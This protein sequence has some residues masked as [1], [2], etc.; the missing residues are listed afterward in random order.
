VSD[1]YA[2]RRA[3]PRMIGRAQVLLRMIELTGS[4][5]FLKNTLKTFRLSHVCNVSV[6]SVTNKSIQEHFGVPD[7]VSRMSHISLNTSSLIVRGGGARS[8]KP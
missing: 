5:S 7:S 1:S 2:S 3:A 4:P 8:A 6:V